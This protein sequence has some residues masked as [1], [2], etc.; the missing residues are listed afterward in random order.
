M[1]L[2]VAVALTVVALS[3]QRPT[4]PSRF[5]KL[6]EQTD[7]GG[8]SVTSHLCSPEWIIYVWL[9]NGCLCHLAAFCRATGSVVV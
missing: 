1:A 9:C 6:A 5:G 4:S 7:A 3:P 8:E 2:T